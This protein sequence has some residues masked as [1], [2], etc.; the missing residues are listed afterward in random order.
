MEARRRE[1]APPDDP[2]HEEPA[3]PNLNNDTEHGGPT[4]KAGAPQDGQIDKMLLFASSYNAS[5]VDSSVNGVS[6]HSSAPRSCLSPPPSLRFFPLH[7]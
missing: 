2:S 1:L 7:S 6:R 4:F 3:A 5:S